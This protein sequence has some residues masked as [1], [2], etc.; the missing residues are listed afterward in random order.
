MN[1]KIVLPI[2]AVVAIG[3][4][5]FARS[6]EKPEAPRPGIEHADDGR[7]H[8]QTKEYGGEETPT[9]GDHASPLAWQYYSTEIPDANTIHNLE[10]GGIYVSYRP[11]LPQE[12]VQR[13]RELFFEPFSDDKFKPTKAIMAPRAANKDAIVISSWR[14]SMTLES[15]DEA[16][17]KEYYLANFGKSPEPSAL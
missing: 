8:V 13:L 17:L 9:S 12:Q 7:N 3:V 6:S 5:V 2:I 10:H 15:F 16:K 14:R 4:V 11:D 1:L